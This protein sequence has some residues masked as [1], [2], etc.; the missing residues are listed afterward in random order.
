MSSSARCWRSRL[1][2]TLVFVAETGWFL[3]GLHFGFGIQRYVEYAVPLLIVCMLVVAARHEFI[4]PLAYA[5]VVVVALLGLLG[6]KPFIGEQW[7][8]GA[9]GEFG[10]YAGLSR[11]ALRGAGDARA[12]LPR[13]LARAP[14]R[15]PPGARGAR[16]RPSDGSRACGSQ[17]E[18]L[19]SLSH[20]RR[21]LAQRLSRRPSLA[22]QG[23][24]RAVR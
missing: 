19:A 11:W 24:G 5:V 1:A 3:N 21:P 16:G 8:A 4:Q 18:H 2:A 23:G 15:L 12:G 14:S 20:D 7:G 6:G 17:R 9:I 10:D 13:R 22:G